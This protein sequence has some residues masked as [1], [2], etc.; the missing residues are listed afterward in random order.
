STSQKPAKLCPCPL[1]IVSSL[2]DL[3]ELCTPSSYPPKVVKK[4]AR[5]QDCHVCIV[6]N[7]DQE[8]LLV[9]NAEK[10]LLA[11][12]WDFAHTIQERTEDEPSENDADPPDELRN[13]L[14]PCLA[15]LGAGDVWPSCLYRGSTI[16][17]FS[18]IHRRLLVYVLRID[19]SHQK[20][21]VE[22]KEKG[23]FGGRKFQ[24]VDKST[25][26]KDGRGTLGLPVTCTKAFALLG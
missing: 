11:N 18:H 2:E 12:L 19:V 24:W 15:Q 23:M 10:G 25:L 14:Q 7:R 6:V 3:E 1:K 13:L 16:H 20:L 17:K 4:Q 26:A 8:F 22:R 9:K 21:N 5:Q